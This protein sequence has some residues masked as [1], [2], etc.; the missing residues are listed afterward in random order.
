M[1]TFNIERAEIRQQIWRDADG[2]RRVDDRQIPLTWHWEWDLAIDTPTEG[3][4][5]VYGPEAI[6]IPAVGEEITLSAVG[7]GWGETWSF[8]GIEF[9]RSRPLVRFIDE[10][11]VGDIPSSQVSYRRVS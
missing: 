7:R 5:V 10:T 6:Y 3:D 9:Q 2:Q 1:N 8:G 4:R 11:A